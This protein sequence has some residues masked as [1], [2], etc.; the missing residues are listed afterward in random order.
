MNVN[1]PALNLMS[2]IFVIPHKILICLIDLLNSLI[3]D[4]LYFIILGLICLV[5]LLNNE[6]IS[7]FKDF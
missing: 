4:M 5:N 1:L 3:W 2:Y 7:I 6:I